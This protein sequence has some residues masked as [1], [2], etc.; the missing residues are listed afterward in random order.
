MSSRSFNV[1]VIGYGLS[2]K[3]FHIPLIITVPEFKL[4][5]ILQRTPRPDNDAS[6]D[7]PDVKIRRTVDEMVKDDK[8]D[9]VVITTTPD[10]HLSLGK[11]ALEAGKHGVLA[12]SSCWRD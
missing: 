1:G 5:S 8:L 6:R 2:A 7:H 4:Y 11:T 3:V 12:F 9:V 10:S